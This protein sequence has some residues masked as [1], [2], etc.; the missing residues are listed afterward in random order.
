MG[1]E[2]EI[3]WC[4]STIN[5]TTG[6]DGCELWSKNDRS[7]Y[8]GNYHE[9]RLASAMPVLY[10]KDFNEVRLV[11]GRVKQAANWADLMGVDRIGMKHVSDKPWLSKYPRIIFISDMGDAPS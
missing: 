5:P 4:D 7:C 1:R 6:C 2:T 8:A 10:A 9:A 3:Q 11:E